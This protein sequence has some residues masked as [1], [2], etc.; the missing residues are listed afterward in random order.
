MRTI[1]VATP[2]G[3]AGKTTLA[4]HLAIAGYLRDHTV[5]LAD[6]DPQRSASDVLRMRVGPGPRRVETSGPKLFALKEAAA[7]AGVDYLV[8]DTPG[9]PEHDVS[10]ALMLSDVTVLVVRPSFLDIASA[11]RIIDL[12]R[13]LGRSAVIVL[14]QALCPRA[15]LEPP[16]VQKAM[17]ALRFTGLP[18]S[19][20]VMRSRAAYQMAVA[21]GRSA[22][23]LGPSA[24]AD[25]IAALWRFL[26]RPAAQEALRR[27]A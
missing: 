17:E 5:I 23:E 14:N 20:V 11:V 13:R 16:S 8:I 12:T 21:T 19:P 9:G 2:K 26:E 25:E 10:Q 6:A 3:G 27:R 15:T 1:A 18:V 4:V 7:R 24:A 22:E